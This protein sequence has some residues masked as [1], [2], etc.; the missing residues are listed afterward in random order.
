MGLDA[1]G[2]NFSAPRLTPGKG[3]RSRAFGSPEM[4]KKQERQV[5]ALDARERR[6]RDN[7]LEMDA[8]AIIAIVFFGLV[9]IGPLLVIIVALIYY[10]ITGQSPE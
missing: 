10:A 5:S 6:S 9:T 8:G 2:R 1:K 7:S 3:S 4:L